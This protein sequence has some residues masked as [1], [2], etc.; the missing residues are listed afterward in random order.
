[1]KPRPLKAYSRLMNSDIGQVI[2]K[3]PY[4]LVT[5]EEWKFSSTASLWA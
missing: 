4:G 5:L 3:W 2:A 1:M